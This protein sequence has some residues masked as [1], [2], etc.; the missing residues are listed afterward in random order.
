MSKMLNRLR[1]KLTP[2]QAKA[3]EMLATDT[4]ARYE[5]VAKAVGVSTVTL[6]AWRKVDAFDE[7]RVAF[8]DK[9]LTATLPD[10]Y[11]HLTKLAFSAEK[12]SIQIKAV[13]LILKTQGKLQDV[14]KIEQTV[15]DGRSSQDIADSLDDLRR[16]LEDLDEEAVN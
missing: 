1:S 5:D 12:E 7:Y 14:K 6:R 8:A 3:A 4:K 16:Q 11:A 10:V 9:A 15:T 2:A 13:E